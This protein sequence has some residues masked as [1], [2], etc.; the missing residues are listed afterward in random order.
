MTTK[1]YIAVALAL[2]VVVPAQAQFGG[3]VVFDPSMF[4]RQAQQLAEEVIEAKA[5]I[6]NLRAGLAGG[7]SPD[8]ALIGELQNFVSMAQGLPL[9]L[10][11]IQSQYTQL[12]PGYSYGNGAYGARYEAP[13]R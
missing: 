4:E 5:M 12:F 1:A 11:Q 2:L 13:E 6:V 7:F 10:T 9:N 3:S 8:L